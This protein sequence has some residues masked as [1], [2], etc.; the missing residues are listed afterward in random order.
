MKAKIKSD[1]TALRR[2]RAARLPQIGHKP[3]DVAKKVRAPRQTV[4]RWKDVLETEGID[5][6]IPAKPV[7]DSGAMPIYGTNK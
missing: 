5:V 2:V 3:A 4:Y 6:R 7:D 1:E